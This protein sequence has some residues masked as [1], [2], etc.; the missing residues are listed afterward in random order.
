[1]PVDVPILKEDVLDYG[2][3]GWGAPT[4]GSPTWSSL[5][6][7][8][9]SD[10]SDLRNNVTTID[11]KDAIQYKGNGAGREF[12]LKGTRYLP[13]TNYKLILPT[14]ATGVSVSFGIEGTGIDYSSYGANFELVDST[15][16]AVVKDRLGNNNTV[17]ITS[18]LPADYDSVW[19][20]YA[21]DTYRD[22]A[23]FYIDGSK[24][25]EVE[26]PSRMLGARACS[27]VFQASDTGQ[28]VYI[29]QIAQQGKGEFAGA[30]QTREKY[31]TDAG[32]SSDW[33][34]KTITGGDATNGIDVSFYSKRTI[35][36][37]ADASGNL[38]IEVQE[39]DGT[40]QTYDTISVSA[41]A[42]EPFNLPE[43]NVQKNIRLSYD[44]GASVTAWIAR[45]IL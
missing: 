39:P 29:R 14:M 45:R 25:V 33:N 2:F 7:W 32:D 38:S 28:D 10:I 43:S 42:L 34:A 6:N 19:H 9:N 37:F 13:L 22:R 40:W 35:Y 30:L 17:D 18:D 24:V 15:F 27:F 26:T 16:N 21:V 31:F 5:V 8:F 23:L 12:V 1:M 41:S 44:T 11:G 36:F 20:W 3:G 4:G